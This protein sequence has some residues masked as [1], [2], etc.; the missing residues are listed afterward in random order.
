M[1]QKAGRIHAAG[2]EREVSFEPVNDGSI[3]N[4]V[5]EVYNA[6]YKA[7]GEALRYGEGKDL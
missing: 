3:N 6:T 2:M 5:D 4:P 1:Q 7:F